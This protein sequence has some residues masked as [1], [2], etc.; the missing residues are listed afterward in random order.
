MRYDRGMNGAVSKRDPKT[1]QFLTGNKGGGRKKG[2]RNRLG[3][4]FI[5]DVYNKWK[6]RGPDVLDRVIA[7]EPATFLRVVAQILPREVE[8][9]TNISVS[10]FATKVDDF[11]QAWE[12]AKKVIGSEARLIEDQSHD[13]A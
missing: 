5:Q 4:Q 10:L 9:D 13:D 3:E 8:L 7:D 6:S 2:S 1:G 11:L 12:I